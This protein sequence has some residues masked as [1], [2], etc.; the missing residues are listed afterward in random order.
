M[1]NTHVNMRKTS[2]GK[3]VMKCL[4]Q[5][6]GN[7]S[8]QVWFSCLITLTMQSRHPENKEMDGSPKRDEEVQKGSSVNFNKDGDVYDCEHLLN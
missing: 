7:M 8:I 1:E 2:G 6:I 4:L 3:E 5:S